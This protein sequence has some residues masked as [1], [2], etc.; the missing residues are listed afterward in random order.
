MSQPVAAH[1]TPRHY[2]VMCGLALSGIVL[3]QLQH[4]NLVPQLAWIVALLIGV[5][6]VLGVVYRARLSP[7]LVLLAIALPQVIERFYVGGL[8]TNPDT[9]TTGFLELSNVLMCVA[10][11]AYFVGHYRLQGLWF[12]VLPPDKRAPQTDKP[13]PPRVRSE[14]TLSSTELALL[15]F[16]VPTFVLLAEFTLLVLRQRWGIIELPARWRQF[17][18]AAWVL[19]IGMFVAAQAFRHWRRLQ[20]DRTSAMLTLQDDLWNETRGEQR[21]INRWLAWKKLRDKK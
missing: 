6:G 12:G 5:V 13:A 14:G 9:R 8:F 16:V 17:V 3:L 18:L 11:L 4:S 21:R 1:V 19:I 7:V 10:A 2:Q 15:V 20:M